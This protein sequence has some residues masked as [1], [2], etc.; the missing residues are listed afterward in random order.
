MWDKITLYK[1]QQV[2]AINSKEMDE[3][4]KMLFT[5]CMVFDYTEYQLDNLPLKK[6]S[7][8]T[9]KIT[10]IFSS[11]FK[12]KIYKRI[13]W[14]FIDA[15]VSKLTFGQ[16]IE[17]AF[18]LSNGPLLN[19]HYVMA[20]ISHTLF[21]KNNADKHREK[22]QYFLNQPITKIMGNLKLIIENFTAF[23]NEY[24]ALFGLDKEV[25][26]DVQEDKF[27]KRYGWIFSASQVAEYER[28]N[29]EQA[30]KLPIRQALNDLSYLKAKALYESEQIKR[31]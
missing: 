19:A 20:S 30:F 6:E 28:I 23:N 24:K 8:L 3:L 1:F 14:Y 27:N 13:G 12:E 22:S 11:D 9:N 21:N 4:D 2:E 5:I 18:F 10:K 25:S 7:K 26:G 16:Y 15:D 31:N 29:L 17:V